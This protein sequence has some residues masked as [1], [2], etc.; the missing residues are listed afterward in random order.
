[1]IGFMFRVL[2]G[3]SILGIVGFDAASVIMTGNQLE[4]T[5]GLAA[6][7]AA[8]TYHAH[9]DSKAAYAAA[10]AV[11]QAG[12]AT[13]APGDFSVT[14]AGTVTLTVRDHATTL[15]LG[16]IPGTDDLT[17]PSSTVVRTAKP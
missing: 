15:V 11:A 9:P 1:M 5:A 2:I 17:Q 3:L 7:Q 10:A 16:H 8:R 12:G 4:R 13:L 14:K 6:D